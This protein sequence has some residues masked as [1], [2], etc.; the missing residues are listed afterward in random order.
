MRHII[1][2][3]M[4]GLLNRE[5]AFQNCLERK[6][7]FFL[8]TDV[9]LNILTFAFRTVLTSVGIHILCV[10]NHFVKPRYGNLTPIP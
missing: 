3:I 8:S 10:F 1:C 4:A 6:P 5:S 2:Q 9:E 7:V